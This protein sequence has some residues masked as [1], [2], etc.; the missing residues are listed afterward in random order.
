[1]ALTAE[2][3]GLLGARYYAANPLHPL[4]HTVANVNL[5]CLNPWGRTHDLAM[6]G[7]GHSTLDDLVQRFAG[8]QGRTVT[9]EAQ[10]EKGTFY[11]SDH[12]EF[13]KVGVPALYLT[14]G[15]RFVGR[16][17]GWGLD[18]ANEY[19]ERDYHKVSDEVKPDWDL[20]GAVED[21]QLL[22]R[23]GYELSSTPMWPVW[24]EGSEFRSR[25]TLAPGAGR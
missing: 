3:Q 13:A 4:S 23:V 12:F 2:E 5:D 17:A 21:L 7:L 19:T 15:T 14:G 16:P 9:A 22:F 10:P 24:K 11:R 1:M 8:E 20:S 18:K 6:V 25:R